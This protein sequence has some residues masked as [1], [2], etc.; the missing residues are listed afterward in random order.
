[1]ARRGSD[2]PGRSGHD[3]LWP[4]PAPGQPCGPGLAVRPL[5]TAPLAR[6]DHRDFPDRDPVLDVVDTAHLPLPAPLDPVVLSALMGREP[7]GMPSRC[8]AFTSSTR[9]RPRAGR[10]SSRCKPP[11]S[12]SIPG[13]GWSASTPPESGCSASG[14]AP[15]TGRPGSS[16]RRRRGPARASR[17]RAAR[18]R[19]AGAPRNDV[20]RR[21]GGTALRTR[22]S[23]LRDFRGLLMGHL[24][25]LHDLTEQR[26]RRRSSSSSSGRPPCCR[27]GTVWRRELHDELGQVLGYVN[28]G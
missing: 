23:L 1:M 3:G 7:R 11:W 16:S 28:A 26:R 19:G 18:R 4:W 12:Y 14:P 10:S 13:G 25:M 9:C 20:R 2:V 6:C 24:L 5:P 22:V 15:L 17:C 21:T 8:S 27:S